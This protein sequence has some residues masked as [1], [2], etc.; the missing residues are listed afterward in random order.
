MNTYDQEL[1][2]AFAIEVALIFPLETRQH[3]KPEFHALY[4]T[5]KVV[6]TPRPPTSGNVE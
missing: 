5:N 4:T 3:M 6:Q 1:K 2:I